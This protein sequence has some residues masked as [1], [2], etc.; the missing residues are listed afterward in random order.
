MAPEPISTAHLKNPSH[1]SACMCIPPIFATQC[2][3]KNVT[4]A[5]KTY[6]TID[7]LLDASFSMRPVYY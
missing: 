5:K 3:D 7:E 2:I 6:A 1:V 4:A